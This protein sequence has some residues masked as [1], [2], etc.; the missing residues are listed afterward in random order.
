MK[1]CALIAAAAL[2]S[3]CATPQPI[4]DTAALVSKM[5]S[6]MDRTVTS[7]ADS[8]AL[9]RKWD[10]VRVEGTRANVQNQ[11][12]SLADDLKIL[13]LAD[14]AVIVKTLT[15]LTEEPPPDPLKSTRSA[16]SKAASKVS[17]DA[18]P[19]KNV[20]KVTAEIAQPRTAA[21]QLRSIVK[22]TKDVND[23]LIKAAETNKKK[24][25]S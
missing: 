24:A 6:E 7:Y 17:F 3:A 14:D 10:A 21:E 9:V 20:A 15:A 1:T 18:A 25:G 4:V 16:A 22:F 12:R 19:L 13:K 11:R 8:L 23:D 2:L 5:S